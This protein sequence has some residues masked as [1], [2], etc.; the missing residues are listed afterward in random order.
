MTSRRVE[1]WDDSTFV[2]VAYL[3]SSH[4]GVSVSF[5]YDD[6]YLAAPSARQIDPAFPLYSGAHQ[7]TGLPGSFS[8]CA[9]D[10]WGRGLIRTQML[11]DGLARELTDV[12]YLVSVS[13]I[14]R[15]GSLR[16]CD[17]G[18][19]LSPGASVPKMVSVG[20]LL[21]LAD[22][23]GKDDPD[24]DAVR[25]LV[26]DGSGSMGGARPKAV[27]SDGGE[28]W[29]AKFPKENDDYDVCAWEKVTLGL[30]AMTGLPVPESRLVKVD[31]RSVLLA[32]RFDRDKDRRIGYVSAM[33]LAGS[34]DHDRMDYLDV[35]DSIMD[36]SVSPREDARDL[37]RRMA[38]SVAV[39]NTDDH[40]RNHGFLAS[41][42]GWTLAPIFDVNPNPGPGI[43]R[44]S[45]AGAVS[46]DEELDA[47]MECAPEFWLSRDE[48][49]A[50]I[51]K[52]WK[53]TSSWRGVAA[54]AGIP[55]REIRR[56]APAFEGGGDLFGGGK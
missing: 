16:F 40:L 17:N 5:R 22:A 15:Q 56:M 51:V 29:M 36:Y 49:R 54:G 50:T 9:P 38:F 34:S 4:K 31:G 12:D 52:T 28:L 20:R 35:L 33:T 37:W 21:S 13:D 6:A 23:A 45:I 32:K 27:V 39:H 11:K 10:R 46:R 44:T 14:A 53:V 55:E 1:V 25:A 30:A 2:G 3:D 8:D 18:V 41:G 48:A 24:I 47:L 43:R 7:S 42:K 19:F 26:L